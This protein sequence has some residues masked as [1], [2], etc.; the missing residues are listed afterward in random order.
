MLGLEI[1]G[2]SKNN[3]SGFPAEIQI[4]KLDE[5]V[6]Y[7]KEKSKWKPSQINQSIEMT[8]CN[9]AN[10]YIETRPLRWWEVILYFRYIFK[11][12]KVNRKPRAKK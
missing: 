6:W 12:T 4:G 2:Y 8:R 11:N 3:D 10:N 1:V 5:S 9:F 7:K